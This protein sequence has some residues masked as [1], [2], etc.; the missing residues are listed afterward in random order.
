MD[1]LE[2]TVSFADQA[3]IQVVDAG[4]EDLDRS[5]KDTPNH[6][7]AALDLETTVIQQQALEPDTLARWCRAHQL[8][9]RTEGLR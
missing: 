1:G 7:M 9:Q 5:L 2:S 6:T 4:D 8:E 3:S